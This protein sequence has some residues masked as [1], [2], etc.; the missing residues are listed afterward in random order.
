MGETTPKNE[1][2]V[3]SHGKIAH[4][5]MQVFSAPPNM[6]EKKP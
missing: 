1:G 3:G 2:N 6:G 4:G 5:K